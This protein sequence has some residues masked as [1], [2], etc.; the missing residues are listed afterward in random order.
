MMKDVFWLVKKILMVTF[1][2]K[3]NIIL[4]LGMPLVGI[5]ISF[6]AYGGSA[7]ATLKVGVVNQD[8]QLIAN[9]TIHFLESLNNV[10]V[11]KI[12]E[13]EVSEKITAGTIDCAITFKQ[14]FSQSLLN[15]HPSNIEIVSIK[16]A[17]ITGF[18][19]SYLYQYL[20][21]ILAISK[22]ADGNSYA[23]EKMY[24]KY[25][26]AD[27]KVTASTLHDTSKSKDMTN[28]TIGFLLMI[29]LF[30]AGNFTEII[31]KEKENRTYFRLLT[32]PINARK[33]VLSN[34][35]V[36]FTVMI[37]QI[38]CTLLFIT[39]VFHI[40]MHVSTLQ[41]AVVLIMFALVAVGL[42]LSVVSFSG[43]SASASALQNLVSTPTCLLAGCFWPVEIMPKAVQRIADFMPQHWA[44]DTISK[45]QQGVHFGSLY[46]NF[47]IL[48]AF[49]AAFFLIAVY[50]FAKNK[51]VQNF[52]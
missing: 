10:K 5:F 22:A 9:D 35:I 31:I 34:I 7:Q 24:T 37:V 23:F 21:N 19:K 28:Q 36:S 33:Y 13:N 44:L 14:G 27:Y 3:G 52:V 17:Q 38:I 25:Q 2:K 1:R 4:Y 8:Q 12:K 45:L 50:K 51:H 6:L 49:A 30:S 32:T 43:S 26:H 18:V 48:F 41:M 46:L 16:G 29:M 20:D 39:K 47:M 15:G 42:S 11:M 40:D